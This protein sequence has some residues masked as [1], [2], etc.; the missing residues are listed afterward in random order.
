MSKLTKKV[1][2]KSVINFSSKEAKEL[3]LSILDEYSGELTRL[4]DALAPQRGYGSADSR[5]SVNGEDVVVVL[6]DKDKGT[7]LTKDGFVKHVSL[8]SGDKYA[9]IKDGRFTLFKKSVEENADVM[10][11][12]AP[13]MD[14]A[15]AELVKKDAD[16]A[17]IIE[18]SGKKESSI[19]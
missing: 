14:T 10:L 4:M 12:V 15:L 18:S 13:D 5:V 17:S 19:S 6:K 16:I 8:S 2:L 3:F 9:V 7:V 1:D 11:G